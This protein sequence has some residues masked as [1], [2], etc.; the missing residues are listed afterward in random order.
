M[1]LMLT[2]EPAPSARM[3]RTSSLMHSHVPFTFTAMIR[4]KSSSGTSSRRPAWVI[5]ALLKA[6]S[7]RP[8]R[9]TVASTNWATAAASATSPVV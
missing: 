7:S 6:P 5:A 2:I 9:S 8:N 3:A 1:L 4:S